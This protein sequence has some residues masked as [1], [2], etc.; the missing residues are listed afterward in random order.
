MSGFHSTVYPSVCE[1][2]NPTTR[3]KVVFQFPPKDQEGFYAKLVAEDSSTALVPTID[4][5]QAQ[6]TVESDRV[7]I[8]QEVRARVCGELAR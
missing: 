7:R 6:A 2:T 1:R 4:A 3:A 5:S 8:F